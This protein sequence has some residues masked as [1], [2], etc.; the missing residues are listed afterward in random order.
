MPLDVRQTLVWGKLDKIAPFSLGEA[1][2]GAAKQKDEMVNFLSFND[3]GH[4]EIATPM[5]PSWPVLEKEIL[6]MLS[7]NQ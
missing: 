1:Y 5:A 3:I 2:V 4:F 6:R 7:E